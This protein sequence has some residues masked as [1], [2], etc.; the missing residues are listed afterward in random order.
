[1]VKPLT[2]GE[3]AKISSSITNDSGTQTENVLTS[4]ALILKFSVKEVK[5]ISY[6]DGKPLKLTF[7]EDKTLAD[8]SVDELMSMEITQDLNTVLFQFMQGIPE[9]LLDP[10]TGEVLKNVEILPVNSVPSKKK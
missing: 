10:V 4:M 6:V 7:N 1:M 2:F 5:G 8:N 9:T 3:K